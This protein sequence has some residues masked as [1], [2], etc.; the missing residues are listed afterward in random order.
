MLILVIVALGR[1]RP[2]NQEF[3]VSLLHGETLSENIK[4]RNGEEELVC[5]SCL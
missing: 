4:G 1:V 2:E 3:E 5:G